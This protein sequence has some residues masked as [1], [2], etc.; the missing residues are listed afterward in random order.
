MKKK[1]AE[2]KKQAVNI[3]EKVSNERKEKKSLNGQ[4]KG[5][6]PILF[7]RRIRFKLIASF[8]IPIVFI[9]ILGV[10]SYQKASS[11]IISSYETSAEQTVGMMN[12]YLALAFD[13]VQTKYKEYLNDDTLKQFYRG[14]LD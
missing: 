12:Q 10:V 13:T 9:I 1:G 4:K 14:L 3:P 7:F 6:N 8:F 2:L 5:K 11:Q